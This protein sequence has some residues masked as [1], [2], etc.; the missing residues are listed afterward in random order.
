MTLPALSI[1]KSGA[2]VGSV[3]PNNLEIEQSLLG[4][5]LSNNRTYYSVFEI[6]TSDDFYDPFH[7]RI[8]SAISKTIDAGRVADPQTLRA[9]FEMDATLNV[10]GGATQYLVGLVAG[11]ISTINAADYARHIQELS[12]RR[13]LIAFSSEVRLIA[14][15]MEAPPSSADDLVV[16]AENALFQIA[17]RRTKDSVADMEGAFAETMDRIDAAHK[18]GGGISGLSGGIKRLDECLSGFQKGF[19]YTLAGRPSMGKT[20]G[21]VTIAVNVAMTGAKVMFN[22]LEMDR[23]Q[24]MQRLIARITGFS[25]QKQMGRLEADDFSRILEAKKEILSLPL[26]IDDRS[27][28]N[29]S[30]IRGRAIRQKRRFGLDFLVIDYLGLMAA[31]DAKINRNYQIEEITKGLK[32]LAKELNIPILLL[33]QINRSVET[34]DDKRPTLADLR[35]SGAIEQDSDVV[36]FVYRHEYYLLRSEPMQ[37]P[38]EKEEVFN[39]RY[40]QWEGDLLRS[41]GRG[42]IIVAKNRQGETGTIPLRYEAWR[43]FFY[44]DEGGVNGKA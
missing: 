6:V 11:T 31:T 25:S 15:D 3:P 9:I 16:K 19:L 35:D 42:E 2:D 32:D 13:K 18:L 27:R 30:Q 43:C 29:I 14:C 38:G 39:D 7:G 22:S 20:A 26:Y 41:R 21:A 37:K 23:T 4:I 5:L 40:A 24:I 8:Y 33:S 12:V 17:E 1:V 34:R 36:M 28:L 44:E 10:A